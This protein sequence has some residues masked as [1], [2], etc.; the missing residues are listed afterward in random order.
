[1]GKRYER[2]S[3]DHFERLGFLITGFEHL[4]SDNWRG[5]IELE[6]LSVRIK[7]GDVPAF[8]VVL[9]GYSGDGTPVVA[10]HD[11]LS[12]SEA[13]AGAAERM[14]NGLLKWRTDEYRTK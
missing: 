5:E 1:M 7:G 2:A 11:G 8:L 12:F 14:A 10:F 3:D 9:R 13:M 6:G 4:F